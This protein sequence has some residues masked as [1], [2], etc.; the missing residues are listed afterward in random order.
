MT[1]AN[2][3]FDELAREGLAVRAV[4]ALVPQQARLLVRLSAEERREVVSDQFEHLVSVNVLTREQ[5][6]IS[7]RHSWPARNRRGSYPR[8]IHCGRPADALSS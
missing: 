3:Q 4:L 2:V 5:A 8:S 6:N 7:S 1:I